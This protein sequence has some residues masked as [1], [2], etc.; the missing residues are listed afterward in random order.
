MMGDWGANIENTSIK[1]DMNNLL[2]IV[3]LVTHMVVQMNK[4][5]FLLIKK[6]QPNHT[7]NMNDKVIFNGGEGHI[8]ELPEWDEDPDNMLY[9]I[10]MDDGVEKFL[11][12]REIMDWNEDP[13]F[14]PYDS[15]SESDEDDYE[16]KP[17]LVIDKDD[18]DI[19]KD[20]KL[21]NVEEIKEDEKE[22]EDNSDKKSVQ[23][24]LINLTNIKY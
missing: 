18:A 22:E 12:L 10:R 20:I 4:P 6:I 1:W 5:H 14:K 23:W 16:E 19:K 11:P 2:L 9:G 21:L 7:P 17:P 13:D 8:F 24:I 15:G 3:F